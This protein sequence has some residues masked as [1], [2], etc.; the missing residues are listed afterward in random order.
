MEIKNIGALERHLVESDRT[1][2]LNHSIDFDLGWWNRG[3]KL[4]TVGGP[5]EV[6]GQ[7]SGATHISRGELFAPEGGTGERKDILQRLWLSM[8]WGTGNRHRLCNK[9]IKSVGT[10]DSQAGDLLALAADQA[11]LDPV[12]AYR[13][14]MP[15]GQT[16]IKYLGPAFITKFTYFSGGPGAE[17][18]SLILDSLV[19]SQLGLGKKNWSLNVY[20]EYINF[21]H[22]QA[23]DLSV[24]VGREIHAD[25]IEYFLFDPERNRS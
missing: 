5:L 18:K 4:Q 25:E 11:R 2:V 23:S 20:E 9:R 21:M 16:A 1:L 13:T 8:A 3:N 15:H 7:Q 12:G 10:L 6:R 24:T 14:L 17:N 19:A 22:Q